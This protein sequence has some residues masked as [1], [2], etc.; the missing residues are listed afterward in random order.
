MSISGKPDVVP[1]LSRWSQRKVDAGKAAKDG[2]LPEE[3]A[4]DTGQNSPLTSVGGVVGAGAPDMPRPA[5]DSSGDPR[6][7]PELPA[8]DSLTHEADFS[9]FMS[10]DVDPGLRNQ[11]MKKL[12]TDPHY[13]FGQMDKLDIYIDDYSQP[14]PIPPEM[15]RQMYQAKSLFLF[16]DEEKDS[17]AVPNQ[18]ADEA[19]LPPLIAPEANTEVEAAALGNDVAVADPAAANTPLYFMELAPKPVAVKPE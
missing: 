15:L 13:Q 6:E 10:K 4:S 14:D 3:T 12:F 5:P 1:F 2:T 17:P 18:A 9:P 19:A 11:A 7:Q 16:D 8:I